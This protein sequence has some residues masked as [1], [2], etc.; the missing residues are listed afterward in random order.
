MPDDG[1]DTVPPRGLTPATLDPWL[2][3]HVANAAPPFAYE[4][5]AAGGSNLTYRVTDS[6][7]VIRILRRPP[8]GRGLESAHDMAREHR[9]IS[10]LHHHGVV[11]VP[12]PI[13]VCDDAAIT[14]A[15]FYV[16]SFVD[17][18]ILRAH[19]DASALTP[20]EAERATAALVN[21]Q[22][23]CH[24]LDLDAAGLAD[25][26]RHEGYVD[27]QLQRWRRQVHAAR[28]R[29][30][31]L[32]DELHDRLR[33]SVPP[34]RAEPGLA[35]GDYRFDN[36]VLDQSC[37]IAAVLDWE[38]CTVGDPI[39]DFAWSLQYWG[40]PGDAMTWIPDPPTL[41]ASF[42]TRADVIGR[43]QRASGLD[44]SDLPWYAAF[45]WWKH[46]CI[47]EGVYARRLRGAGGGAAGSRVEA[48]ARRVE[49][50]LEHAHELAR[51]SVP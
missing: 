16:M 42:G 6:K 48:I 37:D 39:A 36:V 1:A 51:D 45:S 10:A 12:T 26:G 15:P 30:L 43:Y 11:P 40:E 19:A 8:E 35:H 33:A 3:T 9:I 17:G 28:V 44:L 27:R 20:E 32:L 18:L 22:V 2:A 49:R 23:T 13:T 21:C 7:G 50:L 46:A 24:R 41:A 29:E 14:G 4:L 34:E 47:V 31:P 25:L 5:I 38:L